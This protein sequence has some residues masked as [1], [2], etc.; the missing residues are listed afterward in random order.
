MLRPL[1]GVLGVVLEL[2]L[3]VCLR[4]PWSAVAARGEVGVLLCVQAG[5][6]VLSGGAAQ[7]V[8]RRLLPDRR[9]EAPW[10]FSFI[11]LSSGI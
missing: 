3:P 9:R 4:L 2:V 11:V 1:R 5:L 7:Q 8:L 10:P 6:E